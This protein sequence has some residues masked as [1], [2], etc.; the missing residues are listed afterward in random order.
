M[1]YWDKYI[2][3]YMYMCVCMYNIGF[4]E[5]IVAEIEECQTNQVADEENS[6]WQNFIGF[7]WT[8][9]ML[10]LESFMHYEKLDKTD[11]CSI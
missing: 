2:H 4:I 8:W 3:I 7:K 1:V 9:L 6:G 11:E 5:T 10:T